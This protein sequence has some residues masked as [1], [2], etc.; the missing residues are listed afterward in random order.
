MNSYRCGIAGWFVVAL[1]IGITGCEAIPVSQ[2]PLSDEQTSRLDPDLIGVWGVIQDPE[3]LAAKP[4]PAPPG[5]VPEEKVT[6]AAVPAEKVPAE[7]APAI[8]EHPPQFAIGHLAGKEHVHE[9]VSLQLNDNVVEVNRLP[10]VATRIGEQRFL[11][12]KMNA[13][14]ESDFMLIKYE[15]RGDKLILGYMLD[16]DFIAQA[17]GRG[18]VKGVVKKGAP[19]DPNNPNSEA[20]KDSIRITAEPKELREFLAKQADKA[21]L[22]QPTWRLERA[23]GN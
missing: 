22:K 21:F 8:A 11:S 23:A 16:R 14:A 12:M 9:L 18:D 6:P 13:E 1:A 3:A 5:L 17:I 20:K 15:P 4:V 10:F 2:H 7:E 19:A